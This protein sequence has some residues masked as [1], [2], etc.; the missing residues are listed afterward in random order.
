LLR[1]LLVPILVDMALRFMLD[2]GDVLDFVALGGAITVSTAFDFA[3][4]FV[5]DEL[6]LGDVLDLVAFDSALGDVLDLAFDSA[7]GDVLD[8]DVVA[9]DSDCSSYIGMF[10]AYILT[11]SGPVGRN[12]TGMAFL[13]H[14]VVGKTLSAKPGQR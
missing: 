5:P 4:G 14:C 2:E 9:F 7:M 13:I 11:V 8:L 3:L 12:S 6:D 10:E 1:R